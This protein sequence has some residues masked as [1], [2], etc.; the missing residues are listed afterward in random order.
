MVT[1]TQP[2]APSPLPDPSSGELPRELSVDEI[3]ELEDAFVQAAMRAKKAG[4]DAVEVHGA[5][6]YVIDAFLSPFSN[7]RTDE[8]GGN[9]EGRARF[10]AEIVS[11]IRQAVGDDLPIIFRMSADEYVSGGLNLP[12]SKAIARIIQDAGAD[13]I[14]VS[15]GNYA[16]PGLITAPTMDLDRAIF[17]PLAEG[18]REAVSIPVIAVGRLHDP[19]IADQVIA[20]NRADLVALGRALLTDPGW[21]EKVQRGEVD[22]IKPCIFCNQACINY[23]LV[24]QPVSCLAN[25]GVGGSASSRSL[26]QRSRRRWWSL[27]AGPAGW[28]PPGCWPS[29]GT[30]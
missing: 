24:N 8:Y 25:P 17:V 9:L 12:Q 30:T 29:A 3:L 6:G 23:L 15:A 5:H 19:A 1:G 7:R 28:R 11:K 13:V 27:A 26:P 14:S 4:F 10:A 2:V 22:E 20:E 18:I 21:A 16:S